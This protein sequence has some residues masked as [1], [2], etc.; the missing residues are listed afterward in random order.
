MFGLF[1][2]C[3]TIVPTSPGINGFFRNCLSPLTG[4]LFLSHQN[5][6]MVRRAIGP[7]DVFLTMNVVTRAGVWR[8]MESSRG[9]VTGLGGP[10]PPSVD[11][12]RALHL[13]VP[14]LGFGGG[15]TEDL[16]VPFPAAPV[17]DD[18]GGDDVHED[19]GE[20]APFGIPVEVIGRF[21]PG[22]IGIQRQRQEQIVPVVDDDQLA[23]GALDGGVIDEVL[24]GAVGTNVPLQ[25]ELARDDFFDGNLLVPA[26]AAVALL[27]TRL[28]HVLRAAERTPRLGDGFSRHRDDS[29]IPR[30]RPARTSTRR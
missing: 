24:L 10:L 22:K 18:L 21:V 15:R 5:S 27:A 12:Y 13:A 9:L 4:L 25:R 2:V 16:E 29:I 23:A 30:R 11:D 6:S 14:V 8:D 20:G 17:L 26:V 28:R 19:F 7:G 3:R 1:G